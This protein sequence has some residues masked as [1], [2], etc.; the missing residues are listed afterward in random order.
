MLKIERL[1][2]YAL[3]APELEVTLREGMDL[4]N[5]AI[6]HCVENKITRL[7]ID[8]NGFTGF[9]F[10]DTLDRFTMGQEWSERAAGALNLALVVRPE[11]ID[12][13]RFGMMVA[14]NRGLYAELFT[15]RD[16]AR[17]WLLKLPD[18]P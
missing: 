11:L 10:P 14:R 17:A 7:L 16:E 15:S 6:L 12:P 4:V 1:E 18:R 13:R 8:T 2:G 3:Y 9:K 5:Q